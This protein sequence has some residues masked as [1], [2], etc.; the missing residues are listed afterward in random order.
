MSCIRS[1]RL[2]PLLEEIISENQCVFV[3]G[4]LISD[5]AVVAFECVH[6]IQQADD[7]QEPHCAYKLDL[8]KAYDYV[9]WGFLEGG[10]EEIGVFREV[11]WLDHAMCHY[12]IIFS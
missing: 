3:P 4:R 7:D 9:D 12:S 11:D 5:N 1:C 10:H 6:F 2:R 8:S